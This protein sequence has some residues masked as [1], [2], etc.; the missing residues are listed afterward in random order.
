[1][2]W[3]TQWC[4]RGALLYFKVVCE[5]SRS[6]ELENRWFGSNLRISG[7]HLKFEFMDRYEMIRIAFRSMV[8]VLYCFF[9]S[10]V[11]FEGHKGWEIDLDL[12][13]DYKAGRSNHI[14]PDLPCHVY[15]YIWQKVVGIASLS[16]WR[17]YFVHLTWWRL[18]RW[19]FATGT[20]WLIAK[21]FDDDEHRPCC[22]I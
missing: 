14:P 5:I 22:R 15:L 18:Y 6:Q 8:E 17:R 21:N 19:C 4:G 11:K 3:C 20:N 10:S 7:W 13:W 2:K 1:M 9:E 12:I 16:K